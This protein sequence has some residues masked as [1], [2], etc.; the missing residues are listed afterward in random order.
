MR[1]RLTRSA[2][3][4]VALLALASAGCALRRCHQQ[5]LRMYWADGTVT[6]WAITV[7]RA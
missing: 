3:V 2:F 4:V 6:T 7:C 5:Q 1:S